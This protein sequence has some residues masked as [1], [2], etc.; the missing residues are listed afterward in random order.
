[1]GDHHIMRR[2]R[3]F[4]FVISCCCLIAFLTGCSRDPNVRKQKYFDSGE[5]Y[6]AAEKYREAAI[7]FANAAQIDPNFVAAHYKLGLT[8]LK[9]GDGDRALVE[10]NRAVELAP[11][12]YPARLDLV[13]TLLA[14]RTREGALIPDYLTQAKTHLDFLRDRQPNSP[15]VYDAW[16]TYYSDQ[17]NPRGA[18][19]EMQ[20]AITADPN[21]SASYLHLALLQFGAKQNDLAEESFKKAV[22]LD[23]KAMNARFALG[24]FYLSN[25]RLPEAEQSF[26][27]AVSLD[28][29]DPQ[30]RGALWRILVAEGQTAQAEAFLKQTKSDL[31]DNPDAYRMLAE[32]YF[33]SGRYDDAFSEYASLYKSHPKDLAV[34]KSYIQ[35]LIRKNQLN[36][37][38]TL[39]DEIL[40]ANAR[41][42][43]ALVSRGQIQL[44]KGDISGA[45]DTLQSALKNEPDSAVAHYQLGVA[46]DQQHNDER[47]EAEWRQ[48][49]RLR[50]DL[51]DAQRALASLEISRGDVDALMQSAQQI[52]A[53]QPNSPD[54]Y[55]LR[56][57]AE[58]QRQRIADADQ[59][60]HKAIQIA[61]QDARTYVELGN[62]QQQQK[63]YPDAIKSYQTGLDHDASSGLALQGVMNCYLAQKQ[64]DQAIAAANAQIAKSPNNSNFYDL[65]GTALVNGKK[66]LKNAEVAFRKAVD[67]DKN[68]PDALRKLARVEVMQGEADQAL[69]TYQQ[70][71]KDNPREPI[72]YIRAGELYEIQNKFDDARAMYQQAVNLQPDNAVASNDLA[73]LML[74]Q[75]GNVDVALSMAQVARRSMPEWAAAADTLGWAYYQKGVYHTAIS[76]F[77]EAIRLN[78]KSGSPDQADFH[79][80]LGLA[81]Q[82]ANQN[83]QARQQLEKVLK[84]NPN[85]SDAG[86]VRK[87]LSELHG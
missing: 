6:L 39:N 40:K 37:A 46:F 74:Q 61:P 67:L 86:E 81:Y 84:I 47:A 10:L 57:T 25:N 32:Y 49:V 19:Q 60:I 27:Q 58:V 16:A 63:Q 54:G 28:P 69:A 52:I 20:K 18:M 2:S 56:A 51:A 30:P 4:S 26:R 68:N 17:N 71:I 76:Q 78:Q 8:Y 72:F 36:D 75:G 15:E 1:M 77:L 42:I 3:A 73:Y 79:Y 43:D 38:A 9:L 83:A 59:D 31:P 21:R 11:E 66:D 55:L 45:V 12:N 70:S 22:A 65:L 14:A 29:K 53:S 64:P 87:A 5:H 44:V 7:Q 13:N 34:K 85:Y 62:L 23:P 50:P 24:F 41:D 33:S 35:L 82:H 80:H 48:A